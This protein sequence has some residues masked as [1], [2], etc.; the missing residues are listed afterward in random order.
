MKGLAASPLGFLIGLL[1]GAFGGGGSLL[2]IPVLVYVV[3]EGVREA[4]ATALV[5]VIA[6]AL[7][8]LASHAYGDK[9]R[10]RA[11]VA[12]GLAAGFSA[13]AGSA[14]NR[15]LDPNLLLLAFTPVMLGGAYAMVTERSRRTA[16]FRP[17][18]LGVERPI[19]IRVVA[20]G[21]GVGWVIGLFGVGGGFVIVPVL[22]LG[23]RFSITEAV[24]TSLLI[25]I[26]GSLFALVER[27]AS[28]DVNWAV[29]VPFSVAAAL[30]AVAG[31]AI[32]ERVEGETLRRAFAAVIV[33]AA[34]YTA[35]RAG[36][37]LAG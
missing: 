26:I 33:L 2:A 37:A 14:L 31:Q 4:Q 7:V 22:V 18:R 12:F 1:M 32:A 10:L 30:G 25:V 17:W 29:A 24:A 5:I 19:V 35:I 20:Y 8:A 3:G 36:T 23:L 11:G 28:G 34:L 21:L 13:L 15:L 6:A 9:V 27:V 16:T